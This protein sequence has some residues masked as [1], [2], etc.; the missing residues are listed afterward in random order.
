MMMLVPAMLTTVGTLQLVS[1]AVV[2]HLY[3]PWSVSSTALNTRAY[4]CTNIVLWS[5]YRAVIKLLLSF[6]YTLYHTDRLMKLIN[7]P[8][9]VVLRQF[10][11]VE[12]FLYTYCMDG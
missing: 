8:L 3:W 11:I 4:M 12:L 5:P 6:G 7:V 1:S 2:Q 10:N 9:S